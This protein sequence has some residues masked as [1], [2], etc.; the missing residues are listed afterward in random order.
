MP[1]LSIRQLHKAFAAPVLDGIS[2]D[3][4]PGEVHALMGAN[5]AGKTTLCNIIYGLLSPDAGEMVYQGA[6]YQ[7][8]SL[9]DAEAKNI[10]MVMQELNLIDNLSVAENMS[11]VEL[12]N[13]WGLINFETL[14]DTA[15][16]TLSR[17][18]L[19]DIDP[20]QKI[21]TLGIGQ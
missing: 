10:R 6:N 8:L 20:R 4:I 11:L 19:T 7:P 15:Q 3:I 18:G 5:G 14:Y 21:S 2:L 9:A 13:N 12:P 17:F 16:D 1:L